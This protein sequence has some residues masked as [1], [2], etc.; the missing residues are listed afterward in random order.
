MEGHLRKLITTLS[1]VGLSAVLAACSGASKPDEIAKDY[2]KAAY[3]GDA[4]K[5]LSYIY[6]PDSVKEKAGSEEMIQGKIK[7]GAAKAKEEA[8]RKG[9][10]KEISVIENQID[11]GNGQ[12]RVIV[13]T[14]FKNEGA[15]PAKD[16]I[17][18]I[19][20]D[21]KWKVNL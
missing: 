3:D 17:K 10:V 6:V 5:M 16:R 13:E 12:G 2:V 8:S 9:G 21:D 4:E 1:A 20:N 19:K 11:E 15:T 14:Q 18:L 7:A